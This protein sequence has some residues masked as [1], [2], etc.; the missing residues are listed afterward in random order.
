MPSDF[1]GSSSFGYLTTEA[2]RA[3]REEFDMINL[4]ELRA[5][6]V[7]PTFRTFGCVVTTLWW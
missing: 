4:R 3:Q 2:L 7:N 1:V 5:S 6:A